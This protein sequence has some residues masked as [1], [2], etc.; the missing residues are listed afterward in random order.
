MTVSPRLLALS[1]ALLLMPAPGLAQE[2]AAARPEPYRLVR[3]LQIMQDRIA[4][5]DLEAHKEQRARLAQ[6]AEQMAATDPEAWKDPKNARAAVT[7]VLSGGDPRVLRN[8]LGHGV[9]VGLDEH[10]VKG[11][12]AYGESRL[13]DAADLFAGIDARALDP[14]LAA[15]VAL[16][17]S[18]LAARK[19]PLKALPYLEDARLLAPGTLVEEA[20]LRRQISILAAAGQRDRFEKLSLHY[21]RRFPR[22][23]YASGFR[24]QF[25]AEIAAHAKPEDRERLARMAAALASLEVANRRDLYLAIAKEAIVAGKPGMARFAAGEAAKLADGASAEQARAKVYEGAALVVSDALER[26]VETLS[27]VEKARLDAHDAELRELALVV[28]EEVRRAPSADA[29]AVDAAEVSPS[30][31][32]QRARELL[33]QVDGMLS[34]RAK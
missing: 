16:V 21:M 1:L 23:V 26:G 12:V 20:A 30:P 29:A 7:F 22:S 10:L 24:R 8:L 28:A 27:G 15:H 11:A 2:R 14:S 9:Q 25:A 3:A 13:G 4:H 5:G 6:I 33:Q 32:V 34:G 18:E 17:Q 31:V 19:D